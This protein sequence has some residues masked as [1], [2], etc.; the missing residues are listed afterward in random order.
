MGILG[1]RYLHTLLTNFALKFGVGL[2]ISILIAR[3]LGPE[4]RGEYSLLVLIV[5][6]VTTLFNFGIPSTN[7]YFTAQKKLD[8]VQLYRASM[9]LAVVISIVT[10]GV[11]YGLYEFKL[12]DK[13]L[14]PTDKLT[15][16]ILAS[17][18]VIPIAFFNLLA[19][20]IIIGENKIEL[21][22]YM[23]LGSQGALALFLAVL[24]MLGALSV[25][26]A[27]ILYAFSHV[28]AFAIIVGMSFPSLS[29][30]VRTRIVWRDYSAMLRFSGTIHLGNLTQFFNYRLRDCSH[31][32]RNL[33][34]AF[35]FHGFRAASNHSGT[36]R[37]IQRARRESSSG[38]IYHLGPWRHHC[39][40]RWPLPHPLFLW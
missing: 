3:T 30:I 37:K 27:I 8:R 39:I 12:F 4:G 20:G 34:A 19:Q 5:T 22:N 29:D 15:P 21:N 31:S 9:V 35:R 18:G 13:F 36:A 32:W 23:S 17:L 33:V 28:L 11:L 7:T 25:T 24:Y 40:P 2:A 26:T 14:F 16:P 38:Y 10:F 1:R 6:T